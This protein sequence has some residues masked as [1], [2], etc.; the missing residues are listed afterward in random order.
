L[1]LRAS[2]EYQIGMIRI[3][4]LADITGANPILTIVAGI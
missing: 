3:T 1:F 2:T 4:A